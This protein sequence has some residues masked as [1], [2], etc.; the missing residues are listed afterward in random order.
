VMWV[1]VRYKVVSLRQ[2]INDTS[3]TMVCC[4]GIIFK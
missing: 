1:T 2:H 4:T 3:I